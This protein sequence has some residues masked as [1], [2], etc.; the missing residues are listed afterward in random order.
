MADLL[1]TKELN[2]EDFDT[3]IVYVFAPVDAF[4]LSWG[5]RTM[6]DALSTGRDSDGA[7]GAAADTKAEQKSSPK[8]TLR[9]VI[10]FL[11]VTF[12]LI[13]KLAHSDA[14]RCRKESLVASDEVWQPTTTHLLVS[15]RKD[16][17]APSQPEPLLRHN[18]HH[19]LS[20]AHTAY[21]PQARRFYGGYFVM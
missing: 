1:T 2:L 19:L 12:F 3:C 21:S 8:I 18:C 13:E 5:A 16:S 10:W 17:V 15:L 11:P 4:Q 7:G 20:R 14:V 6:P 9:I